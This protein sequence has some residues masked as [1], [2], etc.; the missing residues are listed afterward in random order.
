MGKI[1]MEIYFI[2]ILKLQDQMERQLLLEQVGYRYLVHPHL[3]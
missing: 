1:L 3:G 2:V